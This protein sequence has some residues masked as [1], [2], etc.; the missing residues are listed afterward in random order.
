MCSCDCIIQSHLP[1]AGVVGRAG[2]VRQTARTPPAFYIRR[3]RRE[4]V[5]L[6]HVFVLSAVSRKVTVGLQSMAP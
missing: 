5:V 2:V 4:S 6:A 3:K 1:V